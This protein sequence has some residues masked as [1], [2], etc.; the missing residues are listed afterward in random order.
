LVF[1]VSDV[2]PAAVAA[3]AALG[4]LLC[5]LVFYQPTDAMVC[6]IPVRRMIQVT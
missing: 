2:S 5:A 3:G 1:L 6:T 4:A